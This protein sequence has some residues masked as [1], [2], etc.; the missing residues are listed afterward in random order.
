MT[1]NHVGSTR[2]K[3]VA[4]DSFTWRNLYELFTGTAYVAETDIPSDKTLT[5]DGKKWRMPSCDE[6]HYFVT[7]SEQPAQEAGRTG[8]GMVGTHTHARFAKVRVDVRGTAYSGYAIQDEAGLSINNPSCGT[9]VYVPGLMLFPDDYVDNTGSIAP[10][11]IDAPT[12][13]WVN[14]PAIPFRNF[15]LMV[16]GGA[17]FLPAAGYY[18]DPNGTGYFWDN[19]GYTGYYWS[20]THAAGGDSYRMAF[21]PQLIR[22]VPGSSTKFPR[23]VRLLYRVENANLEQY[24]VEN[25]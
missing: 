15:E 11:Q 8:S 2:P 3:D 4:W 1:L 16:A 5:I 25:F 10:N 18:A 9:P 6:W 21:F 19:V 12:L 7:T 22:V 17:D 13:R 14:A 20:T 23:S 24:G